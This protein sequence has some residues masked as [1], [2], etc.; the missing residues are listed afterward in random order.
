MKNMK[1]MV[2]LSAGSAGSAGLSDLNPLN[3]IRETK[4]LIEMIGELIEDQKKT[5]DRYKLNEPMTIDELYALL[6][7]RWDLPVTYKMKKY[8]IKFLSTIEFEPFMGARPCLQKSINGKD[9]SL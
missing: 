3:K 8:W 6:Q 2:K 1:N 4:G 9:V 5:H 7:E